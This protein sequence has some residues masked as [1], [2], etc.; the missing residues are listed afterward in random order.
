MARIYNINIQSLVLVFAPTG[1][2]AF[3]IYRTTIHS[4]LSIPI[5]STNLDIDS[6]QL[7]QLQKRLNRDSEEQ[8]NFRDILLQLHNKQD[9]FLDA[10]YIFLQKINVNEFNI[11]K[12][13]SLNCPIARINAIHTDGNEACK[14]DYNTAKGLE[15]QL[16]LARSAHVMLRTNL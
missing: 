5:G 16:F 7:K 14:A 10:I 9:Y 4:A 3:N 11:N 12:L 13:K 2:V 15:T 1:V 6:K 8:H